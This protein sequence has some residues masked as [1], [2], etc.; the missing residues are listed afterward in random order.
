VTETTLVFEEDSE[1]F[2][3]Q[4]EKAEAVPDSLREMAANFKHRLEAVEDRECNRSRARVT[5]LD[6]VDRHNVG[7]TKDSDRSDRRRR[8]APS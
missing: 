8:T 2:L 6:R 1:I 7:P 4:E 5:P 3:Q